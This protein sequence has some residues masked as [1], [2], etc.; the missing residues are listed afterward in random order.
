MLVCSYTEGVGHTLSTA[1]V[2]YTTKVSLYG[3]DHQ[4]R[5]ILIQNSVISIYEYVHYQY[6][7]VIHAKKCGL[8]FHPKPKAPL[9]NKINLLKAHTKS[10]QN[11]DSA[12]PIVLQLLRVVK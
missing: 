2:N 12:P 3:V 6:D 7:E 10:D 5:V 1:E 8:V 4:V 9:Q 11:I